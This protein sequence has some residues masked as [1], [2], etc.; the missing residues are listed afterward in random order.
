MYKFKGYA[1]AHK[2]SPKCITVPSDWNGGIH[3]FKTP[4]TVIKYKDSSYEKVESWGF[5]A[6]TEKPNK[7]KKKNSSSSTSTPI[8]ELFKLHL[9]KEYEKPFLPKRLGFKKA[10]TD[11]LRELGEHL[12]ETLKSHW[13]LLD[14]YKNVLIVFTVRI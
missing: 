1:Y 2:E 14:F 7:K 4:L 8:A 6:L 3:S 5:P 13:E 10:I 9:L 12:K 11:Y